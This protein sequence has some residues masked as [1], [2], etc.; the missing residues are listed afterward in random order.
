[1]QFVAVRLV[2]LVGCAVHRADLYI[3]I[4]HEKFVHLCLALFVLVPDY[5][6]LCIEYF[7]LCLYRLRVCF[8]VLLIFSAGAVVVVVR[9]GVAV[10]VAWV[11]R[12]A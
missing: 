11:A 3:W 7:I 4:L 2:L 6:V 8:V 9:F 5:F 10:E 1:M 12:G